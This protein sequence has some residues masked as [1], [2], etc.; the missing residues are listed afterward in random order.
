[1]CL[2][3]EDCDGQRNVHAVPVAS[4][5]YFPYPNNGGVANIIEFNQLT[6]INAQ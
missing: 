6:P 1:M 3:P 5:E 2:A 4:Q